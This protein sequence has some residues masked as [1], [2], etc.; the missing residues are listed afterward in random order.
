MMQFCNLFTGR[1]SYFIV[2][3]FYHKNRR[4]P[5]RI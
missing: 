1:P 3:C 5:Y 4:L 2:T